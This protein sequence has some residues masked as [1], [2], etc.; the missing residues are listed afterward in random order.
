LIE[1]L[2]VIAIIAILIGLLLPAVQKVREAAARTQSQNNLKQ[3]A[4]ACHNVHDVYNQ[5]PVGWA[6][7]WGAPNK[8]RGPSTDRNVH[9]ILLAFIEQD[10]IGKA[11]SGNIYGT[12]FNGTSYAYSLPIKTYLSPLDGSNNTYDYPG[13]QWGGWDDW[14]KS[15][16][17]AR[18]NYAYNFQV[19]AKPDGSVA[20]MADGWADRKWCNALTLPGASDGTSNTVAFAERWASCPVSASD[21]TEQASLW[22]AMPYQYPMHPVFHGAQG[23]PVTGTTPA[24]CDVRRVAALTAGG[25]NIAMLDGSVRSVSGSIDD[26]T[27]RAVTTPLGGEVLSGNW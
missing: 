16:T 24:N 21:R 3:V 7:W 17:F 9:S 14:I 22:G 8:Y 18:T 2:V 5:L 26:A 27:W 20:D 19:F 1:L 4:L 10:A 13:S 15:R 12:V 23:R 25:C 11:E 6:V